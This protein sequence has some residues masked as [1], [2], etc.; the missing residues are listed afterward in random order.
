MK[1]RLKEGNA[2]LQLREERENGEMGL[3]E[4]GEMSFTLGGP[5]GDGDKG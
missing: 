5:K 3:P 2:L 4:R 1:G